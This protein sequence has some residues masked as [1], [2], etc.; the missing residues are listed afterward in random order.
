MGWIIVGV[1]D[2]NGDGKADILWRDDK[3]NAAIW[4]MN[5]ITVAEYASTGGFPYWYNAAMTVAGIG[6]FDGDGAADVLWSDVYGDVAIWLLNGNSIRNISIISQLPKGWSIAGT[7]DFD[8]DG[9][10]DILSRDT[11]GNVAV[12][13][14][15]GT[16]VTSN[17]A[18]GNVS[19]RQAQ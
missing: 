8:G 5:G 10:A 11:A 1:G 19:D 2:F 17:T 18:M 14:M 16:T 6:D 7:G 12:W 3:G 13:L 15:D 4:L 9:K